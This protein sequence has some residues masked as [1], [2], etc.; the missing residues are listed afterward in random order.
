MEIRSTA[1]EKSRWEKEAGEFDLSLSEFVRIKMNDGKVRIAVKADPALIEELRR[2]GN[3]FNQLMHAIHAGFPVASTRVEAAIAA[4]Q[5]A[6]KQLIR[7][8]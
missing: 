8:G 3:N 2:H 1:A 6:Y 4:L 7:I 5:D